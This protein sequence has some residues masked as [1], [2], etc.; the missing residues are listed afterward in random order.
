MYIGYAW[1]GR[2][3]EGK[4]F[5]CMLVQRSEYFMCW[6][7]GKYR[8]ARICKKAS[9]NQIRGIYTNAYMGRKWEDTS[10]YSLSFYSLLSLTFSVCLSLLF[11]SLNS[12]LS[13]CFSLFLAYLCFSYLFHRSYVFTNVFLFHSLVFHLR[14]FLFL[15]RFK[16]FFLLAFMTL[17]YYSFR[18]FSSSLL[19]TLFLF[20]VYIFL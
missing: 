14:Q 15:Y 16:S 8:K 11:P 9:D 10:T 2:K 13:V 1:G 18:L 20:S 6:P 19:F 12:Y 4:V 17:V 7:A 3:K 5:W